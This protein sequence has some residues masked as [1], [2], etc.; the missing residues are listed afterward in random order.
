MLCRLKYSFV[1]CWI[2]D[3]WKRHFFS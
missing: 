3:I 1:I 2:N